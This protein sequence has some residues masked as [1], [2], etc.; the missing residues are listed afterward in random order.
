MQRH[1]LVVI[2]FDEIVSDKYLSCVQKAIDDG[3]L[4]GYSVIDLESERSAINARMNEVK[5]KPVNIYYLPDMRD[6]TCWADP[7]IFLPVLDRLRSEK[8]PLRV[9]IATEVKAHEPYLRYCVHHGIDSLVEKPVIAP[10]TDGRFDPCQIEKRMQQLIAAGSAKPALHSVMTLSRYHRIYNE[11]VIEPL[12]AK[13]LEWGAPLTSFHLRAAGG[14]W[15]LHREYND[16][17]DHPYKYGY[18]MLMHGAYHYIDLAAQFLLLNKP[19]FP[20]K[21]LSFSVSSFAA[22]PTDQYTRI[23]TRFAKDFED[24]VSE[25]A[26]K[27]ENQFL[28][29]ETDLTS[30]FCI[31]DV[32]T[33]RVLTLGTLAFEQTTPSIR[34]WKDIPAGLY[35]KNG[36]TSSIDL[37]AQLSTLHSVCVLVHDLPLGKDPDKIDAFARISTRTNASLLKDQ[38]YNATHE[39]TGLFHSDSNRQLMSHWLAGYEKK[40]RLVDHLI[41]MQI[42]QA[43]ALSIRNP[44]FP[45]TVPLVW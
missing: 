45:V 26:E 30:T 22:Y 3:N 21:E 29:G 10:L 33:A 34:Y 36:R 13:V 25:W 5:L 8:S 15:N 35:N 1:H 37:E 2:G 41:P 43:L 17:E 24:D 28:Y 12:R 44:G 4:D 27:H 7:G 18:G 16:R 20:D 6:R 32:K 31:R 38:E 40:S 23:P 42:T 11:N 14:V 19:L 39:F 9:Y